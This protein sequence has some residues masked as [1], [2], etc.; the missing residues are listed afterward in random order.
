VS[1]ASQREPRVVLV[2]GGGRG[3]GLELARAF[4]EAGDRLVLC[5]REAS[6]LEAAAPELEGAAG[7]DLEACDVS[8]AEQ[9]ARLVERTLARHGHI[10]V[11]VNNAG[12]YGPVGPVIDNDP[13]EWL[14]ALKVNLFGVFLTMHHAGRAMAARGRGAIVNL[15]GGGGTSPKPRYSCYAASK[16]GVLRLTE[17]AAVELAPQGVRVNAIAP[18]FI[19]TRIHEATLK[20][21]EASGELEAVSAKLA[22]GGDDPRKAAELALFLAGD[23]AEGITGRLFSAIFD[24]WKSAAVRDKLRASPHL[25]TLRRIDD[26]MFEEIERE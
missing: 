17:N 2:T 19:A 8:S 15:S 24:D 5:G 11:L 7:V 13:A 25:F 9:V 14:E 20:A 4:A 10:D 18:G 1:G 22:A 12:L 23:E 3:L 6:T 21:G 16:T 26:F